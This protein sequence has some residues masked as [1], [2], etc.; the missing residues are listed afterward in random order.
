MSYEIKPIRTFYN[1]IS[2]RSQLEAKWAMFFDFL[3]LEFD[4][5]P[6]VIG[7]WSVDFVLRPG[8]EEYLLEV[9]PQS[10]WNNDV[11]NKIYAHSS[12][13]KCLLFHDQIY[14]YPDDNA[15]YLGKIFNQDSSK[16]LLLDDFELISICPVKYKAPFI[17]RKWRELQNEVQFLK[18]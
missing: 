13:N 9:K 7:K 12:T 5:E 10:E 14:T 3:E 17:L 1:G 2:Y 18:A 15:V 6:F 8:I 11:I 16:N 4:Y